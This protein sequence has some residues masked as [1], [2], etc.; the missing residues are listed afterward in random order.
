MLIMRLVIIKKPHARV[1]KAPPALPQLVTEVRRRLLF[2]LF[3]F[4]LLLCCCC[5]GLSLPLLSFA[6]DVAVVRETSCCLRMLPEA[7]ST[8]SRSASAAAEADRLK[9]RMALVS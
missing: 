5:C 9:T 6:F 3:C 4:L 7:R 8:S 2:L 1:K